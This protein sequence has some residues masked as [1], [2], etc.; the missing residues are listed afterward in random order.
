VTPA[1]LKS[2]ATRATPKS[3]AASADEW[4]AF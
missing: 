2:P 3:T 1:P 4:V